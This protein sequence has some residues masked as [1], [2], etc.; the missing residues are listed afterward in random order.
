MREVRNCLEEYGAAPLLFHLIS[1]TKPEEFWPLIEREIAARNFFLLCDSKNARGSEW[2]SRKR[3][4]IRKYSATKPIRVGRTDLDTPEIDRAGLQKFVKNTKVFFIGDHA[5]P[6]SAVLTSF[7]FQMIGGVK[8]SSTG[9]E[10]LGDGSQM[11]VDMLDTFRYSV[12]KGW[13]LVAL[14][15]DLLDSDRFWNELP[16]PRDDR[17]MFIVPTELMARSEQRGIQSDQLV[18]IA[19]TVEDA[20]REAANRMLVGGPDQSIA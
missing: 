6:I 7:G 19:D 3:E 13:V 17:V 4:A 5:L 1:L 8:F 12:T 11:S 16:N 20:I 9:L 18:P 2:V 10:R 14:T 15:P